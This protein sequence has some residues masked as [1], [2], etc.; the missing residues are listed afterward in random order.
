M[1]RRDFAQRLMALGAGLILDDKAW[2]FGH[3]NQTVSNGIELGIQLYS[4]RDECQRDFS[5]TL[6]ALRGMGYREV[7][8]FTFYG[9][10]AP[11]IR[12]LLSIS[13]LNCRS[14]HY[15][16]PALGGATL[17]RHI[18]F[19]KALGLQYMVSAWIPE[20]LRR[21]RDDYLRIADALNRA[22]ERCR[23]SGIQLLYHNHNFEFRRFEGQPAFDLLMQ[24]TDPKLVRL[25][26][27]CYWMITAGVD[28]VRY[29]ESPSRCSLLHIKDRKPG[30]KST[31]EMD[32]GAGAFT[33]L[34]KGSIDYPRII[35]EA[36]KS[37]VRLAYIDQDACEGDPMAC[38]QDNRF[39]WER[40][41]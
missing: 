40:L 25:E 13:G 37:G 23:K 3:A 33:V 19:A 30:F 16:Y 6:R 31:T 18:E 20:D 28:P 17:E 10:T 9:K 36:E 8:F 21:T 38:A 24:K 11:E 15:E 32:E 4:V 12:K 39:G 29:I 14:A 1:N 22:G 5:G 35:A 27:D 41:R 26:V 34:G 2:G 7:E